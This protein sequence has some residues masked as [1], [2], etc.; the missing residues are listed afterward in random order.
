M[1]GKIRVVL[2]KLII[3]P[4]LIGFAFH[5]LICIDIYRKHSPWDWDIYS[6]VASGYLIQLLINLDK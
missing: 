2:I 3:F 4:N 5:L 6:L 1:V